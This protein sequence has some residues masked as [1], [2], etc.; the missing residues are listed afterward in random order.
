MSQVHLPPQTAFFME[1]ASCVLFEWDKISEHTVCL[2]INV[3][4]GHLS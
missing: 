3:A 4:G 1:D 2:L